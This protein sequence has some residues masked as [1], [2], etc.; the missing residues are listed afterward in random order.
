MEL[1]DSHREGEPLTTEVN[2]PPSK[3]RSTEET[4]RLIAAGTAGSTGSE[5]FRSLVRS[6][7]EVWDVNYAFVSEYD[8][9]PERARMVAF[10]HRGRIDESVE[11][12]LR[13]TPCEVVLTDG[14]AKYYPRDVQRLFPH[15]ASA[16]PL[17]IE[18]YVAIPITDAEGEIIGHIG[19]FDQRPM[20]DEPPDF[21]IF[22]IFGARFRAERDRLRAESELHRAQ[23]QLIA[24][25][26]LAV[27]G[28]L[29]SGILHEINTPVGVV[30][31]NLDVM[32][33]C[34]ERLETGFAPGARRG[35]ATDEAGWLLEILGLLRE[36]TRL[37]RSASDRIANL[38]ERLKRFARLDE[39]D[40]QLTDL[41]ECVD[42]AVAVVEKEFGGKVRLERALAGLPSIH[43]PAGELNQAFLSLLT[44][45][46]EAVKDGGTV[47]LR[48][49]HDD[50]EVHVSVSDDGVG[51]TPQE[52]RSLYDIRMRSKDQRVGIGLGMAGVRSV[53]ERNGGRL[54]VRSEAG[55]GT[56][57]T[58]SFPLR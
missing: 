15:D 47:S 56:E 29:A 22:E 51:M 24:S 41:N 4:L 42:S 16:E 44:N 46:I 5:F 50:A 34:V 6:L 49:W 58:V 8:G 9:D 18:S 39:A 57:V 2:P 25:E 35:E 3:H 7:A 1:R 27:I 21:S 13:G 36:N 12:E 53:V 37:S 32:E 48:S 52:L 54:A 23:A 40:R 10:Y 19:V 20:P 14:E 55:E 28:Q 31:S 45:A 26:R 38:A 33:R 43:V 17:G 30:R 11:Y